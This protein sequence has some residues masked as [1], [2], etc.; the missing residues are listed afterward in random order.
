[1]SLKIKFQLLILLSTGL[2]AVNFFALATEKNQYG[3]NGLFSFPIAF[4]EL[5]MAGIENGNLKLQ[6]DNF[7]LTFYKWSAFLNDMI[8]TTHNANHVIK[9][10]DG[11][12]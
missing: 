9:G 6:P 5:T 10:H 8:S 1:M 2:V 12:E 11:G 3:K 4:Y 7:F